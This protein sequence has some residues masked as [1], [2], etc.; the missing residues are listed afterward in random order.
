MSKVSAVSICNSLC[1]RK[2]FAEC[3][4]S[5]SSSCSNMLLHG[6]AVLSAGGNEVVT[7]GCSAS[8]GADT[9][10]EAA[11]GCCCCSAMNFMRRS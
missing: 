11:P 3:S 6:M 5:W 10:A 7:V 8:F 2:H 1:Y 9:G 4:P